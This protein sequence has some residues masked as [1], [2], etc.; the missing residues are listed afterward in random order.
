MCFMMTDG[1]ILKLIAG[2]ARAR[3]WQESYAAR[4]VAGSG[5]LPER[6]QAGNGVTLRRANAIVARASELWPD[7]QPWPSDIPRPEPKA[8]DAA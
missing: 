4:L 1:D 2:L 7:D 3:G 8:E 6:L 5:T